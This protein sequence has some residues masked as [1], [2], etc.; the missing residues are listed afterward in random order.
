[1]LALLAQEP[2]ARPIPSSRSSAPAHGGRLLLPADPAAEA[3]VRRAQMQMQS[4]VE[5]GRR[6]RHHRRASSARSRDR[7]R[8]GIVTVEIAP[9]TRHPDGAR[10]GIAQRLVDDDEF[11]RGRGRGRRSRAGVVSDP[12]QPRD[13][14]E[15][16]TAV[17]KPDEPAPRD[18][19]RA[20]PDPAGADR[21][22]VPTTLATVTLEDVQGNEELSLFIASADRVMEAMGYTE[23]GFR[24][25]NLVAKHR[26]PGAHRLGYTEREATLAC[27]AGYL[28]DVGNA[29]ARDAHGQ[30]GAVLVHQSLRELGARR[31]PDAGPR[32]DREPRGDRGRRGLADLGG[33]DPRRQVGRAP[34]PRSQVRPDRVRHPRP[35]ELRRRA[36]RSCRVDS[37]ARTV[38]L[39]LTIDTEISQVMEY[40]EIFLGR[41]QLCRHAAELL[42]ARFR[43]VINGAELA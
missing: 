32:G 7:R 39:E 1:M 33:G 3:S 24:H 18:A 19:G 5:V 27:V 40:F 28:H 14:Q 15:P 10:G 8:Y 17:R 12:L 29:L 25:A 26:L 43:L 4:D 37:A 13:P 2:R 30:T 42:D 41:M 22:P 9:G 21:R 31:G 16:A 34:E 36:D 23:H 38:S 6:D 35:G 11:V 20:H